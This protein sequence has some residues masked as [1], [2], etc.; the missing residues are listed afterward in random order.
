MTECRPYSGCRMFVAALVGALS[1]G[2]LATPV[3]AQ[4]TAKLGTRS[5]RKPVKLWP[6]PDEKKAEGET[7]KP[8]ELGGWSYRAEKSPNPRD[9]VPWELIVTPV[10]KNAEI[11][12]ERSESW[13]QL[14][15]SVAE[16]AVT[17]A[18][19]KAEVGGKDPGEPA[20][21]IIIIP[22]SVWQA[23]MAADLQNAVGIHFHEFVTDDV[24]RI[25]YTLHKVP[26]D[27]PDGRPH[28]SNSYQPVA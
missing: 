21:P 19:R 1:V 26:P 24:A 10:G 17:A 2:L 22:Q 23:Q 28:V 4:D 8:L 15:F 3:D 11:W 13:R 6:P 20:V 5:V 9:G 7:G 14:T 25:L 18:M 12:H 27:E 16:P